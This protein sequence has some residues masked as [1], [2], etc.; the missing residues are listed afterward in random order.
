MSSIVIAILTNV[1]SSIGGGG[2]HAL[3]QLVEALRFK[4][5]GRGFDSRFFD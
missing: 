3:A 5:E 1:N 4:A 2:R